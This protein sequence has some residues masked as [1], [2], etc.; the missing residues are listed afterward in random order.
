MTTKPKKVRYYKE[1]Y[2]QYGFIK[3]QSN[4]TQPLSIFKKKPSVMKL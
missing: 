1:D 4:K 3:N 2:L